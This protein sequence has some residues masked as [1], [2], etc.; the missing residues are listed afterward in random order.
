MKLVWFRTDLR[1]VDN[2]ALNAALGSEG[3]VV[4][5]FIATPAQWQYHSK[6]PMQADLIYRRLIRLQRELDQINIPLLYEE[7]DSFSDVP[8]VFG[9]L[10]KVLRFNSVY[11]NIEYEFD[12]KQRDRQLRVF[13]SRLN[14]SVLEYHDKCLLKPGEVLNK[15]G[16]FF[17]VFTPFKSA[18]LRLISVPKIVVTP[19]ALRVVL[20]DRV[21]Q[22]LFS[23][24]RPFSSPRT[25]SSSW[26]VGFWDIRKILRDFCKNKL[27][28][29]DKRRDYPAM[30]GTSKLSP[31]L[32]I[33]ALSARQCLARVHASFLDPLTEGTSIWISELIWREFF[34]HLIYFR[35]DLCCGMSFHSWAKNISWRSSNWCY[36]R[37]TLGQTGYPIVDAAMRQL[38]SEGWIHNR[39]RM[40]AAS[41]L[42][43]DLH[44][45]WRRG[46]TY[47][48]SKL[49]DGN[50]PANNGGWQWCA[51][52][53]CDGQ[54][55]FQIFNPVSQGQRFDSI[56]RFVRHWVPELN[57][58]PDVFTHEPWK[59]EDIEKLPYTKPLINHS[60]EREVTLEIYKSAKKSK[61]NS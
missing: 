20:E 37:W 36:E 31:Y 26:R 12:E 18:C 10:L 19:K 7:V 57:P 52:T 59:W 24:S 54:P 9:S 23:E 15:R 47:F 35:P 2:T 17:R 30:E 16:E 22:W 45:D 5:L 46:E 6:S 33:G 51:S 38:N 60:K 21:K 8:Y 14:I 1:A 58:V 11:L 56:G 48:M 28:G 25:D 4:A 41:F 3:P 40:I 39:L 49:I 34:Q 43:K 44:V 55:Y 27:S 32:A 13:L 50:Y 61:C 53:G 29:Y 42:V